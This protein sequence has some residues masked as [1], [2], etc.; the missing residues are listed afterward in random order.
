[1]NLMHSGK[2][3]WK[4]AELHSKAPDGKHMSSHHLRRL[5]SHLLKHKY[6]PVSAFQLHSKSKH[7]ITPV[8]NA[9]NQET[10][11]AKRKDVW[12]QKSGGLV[13]VSMA[14]Y[15]FEGPKSKSSCLYSVCFSESTK[16]IN[17]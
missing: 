14:L 5:L 11:R 9:Q 6:F 17:Q 2:C 16:W 10:Y 15:R 7:H 1:M 12:R 8:T 13:Q 4:S 3:I